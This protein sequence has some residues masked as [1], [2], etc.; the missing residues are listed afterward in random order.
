MSR[1]TYVYD[2][3]SG[4]MVEKQ[5]FRPENS[6]PMIMPDIPDFV[7]PVD[8]T[9]VHGRRS[10]REH[11]KEHNVTN[12]AD[13]KSTWD[14]AASERVKAFTPGAGYD[15]HRRKQHIVRSLEQLRRR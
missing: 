13:F 10:L 5:Y 1:K 9:L 4:E 8:G 15:S 12:V 2:P 14:K 6:A 7:S 3:V 11:N